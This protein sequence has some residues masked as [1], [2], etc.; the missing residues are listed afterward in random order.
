MRLRPEFRH[1]GYYAVEIRDA[2][3]DGGFPE[4]QGYFPLQDTGTFHVHFAFMTPEPLLARAATDC[5]ADTAVCAGQRIR[6]LW[7]S[8][9]GAADEL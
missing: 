7:N 2:A 5:A 6:R 9:R 8:W 4:L 1:S 3:D